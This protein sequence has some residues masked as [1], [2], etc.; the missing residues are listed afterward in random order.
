MRSIYDLIYIAAAAYYYCTWR[1]WHV[2]AAEPGYPSVRAVRAVRTGQRV[3]AACGIRCDAHASRHA[4]PGIA[5]G[6]DRPRV[7]VRWR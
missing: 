4:P 1:L 6:A 3:D 5:R 2:P 7:S